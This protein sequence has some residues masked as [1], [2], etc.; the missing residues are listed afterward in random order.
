MKK[1]E[2][3]TNGFDGR[4]VAGAG[5]ILQLLRERD[6]RTRAELAD[7]TGLARS[8]VAQRLELLANNGLV[9]P[10][11]AREST[12]GRPPLAVAFN[13]RAGV[14]I[15]ADLG[16]THSRIAITDLAGVV[17]CEQTGE[18]PIAEGPDRVLGWLEAT[19]DTLL[20]EHGCTPSTVRAVGVGLPGPVEFAT[21][22]PVLPPIM[23]GW[24]GYNVA[25]RL[26]ERY[27]TPVLVDNDVNIMAAGEHWSQWRASPHLLFVKVATGIGCGIIT[28]G[29]IHR[30]AQGAAG[31]IGHV[32]VAGHDDVVCHCGNT[33]CL[34]AVASGSAL[35]ARLTALGVEAT[36]SR[37]VVR[38]VRH[39][40]G[41]AVTAVRQA[42]R[43]I[44]TVLA[45]AVNFFNPDVIVIGGDMA[46]A[47]EALLAGIR[48]V[49]Y[50][51]STPLATRAIRIVRSSLDDRAGV[52]GAAVMAIETI[53]EPAAIDRAL[54]AA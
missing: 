12:G 31:D 51:R 34:E 26:R 53:L 43:E 38:H 17:L 8:T 18:V 42:G 2:L 50:Q 7:L 1:R 6:G 40:S 35:A 37:E 32:R 49:I 9:V 23:P 45:A 29:R 19:V 14:V 28:D 33:G 46:H 4:A 21:G 41:H 16:A 48:E 54:S 44:G 22:R 24:D 30:G 20:E 3:P 36:N 11:G 25:E 13:P 10:A 39:G 47:D 15:A 27:G 52:I 5:T